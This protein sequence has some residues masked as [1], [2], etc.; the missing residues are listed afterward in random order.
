MASPEAQH[1][2]PSA[3]FL[4]CS[5]LLWGTLSLLSTSPTQ[6]RALPLSSNYAWTRVNVIQGEEDTVQA[7]DKG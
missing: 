7:A 6:E 2:L 5:E 3:F 1:F 4:L